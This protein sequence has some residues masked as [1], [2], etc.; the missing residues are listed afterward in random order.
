MGKIEDLEKRIEVLEEE[1]KEL[2]KL[3]PLA[4]LSRDY[5]NVLRGIDTTS[6]I[7]RD[8]SDS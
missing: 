7:S 4:S 2:A 1:S 8:E 3:K 5:I 6:E